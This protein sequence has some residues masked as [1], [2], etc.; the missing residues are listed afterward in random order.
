MMDKLRTASG[1]V[2]LK[3]L[4]GAI[5][6]S[7]VL[8]GVGNYLVGSGN[9][10]AVKV[11]DETISRTQLENAVSNARNEQKQRL[12]ELYTV[13]AAEPSYVKQLRE[14][15]LNNL[16]D[17][18]LVQNYLK[19]LGLH[20][21]DEQVKTFIFSVD[22]FKKDGHFNNEV[23]A[24]M[25]ANAGYTPDTYAEA[26]RHSLQ[27]EQLTNGIVGSDFMLKNELQQMV[28]LV[29]Q[30]RKIRTAVIDTEQLA[31]KQK[32]SDDEIQS[33]YQL[34]K[35]QYQQPD[36]YQVS[37]IKLDAEKLQK[38]PDPQQV[39]AWYDN[40]KDDYTRPQRSRYSVIQV[41]TEQQANE[42]LKKLQQGAD[43][44]TLAKQSSIDVVSSKKGGD[45]G[46]LE[47]ATTPNEFKS[48]HLTTKGQLSSVIKSQFGFI[49]VRLDDVQAAE[50][51][52]LEQVRN[53]VLQ[54]VQH[55]TAINQFYKLQQVVNDA[56]SNDASSLNS[57]EQASGIK[58]QT[59]EWFS[60]N[61]VPAAL[62]FEPVKQV[63]FD[64]SLLPNKSSPGVNSGTI[65]VDGDRAFV[66]RISGFKPAEL[67]PLQAVHDQV[68]KALSQQKAL[69]QAK[70]LAK[71]IV[72]QLQKGNMKALDGAGLT[73]SASQNVERSQRG[74]VAAAAFAMTEPKD[75][76]VSYSN[77][78]DGKNN[79]VII[80]LD[81]VI[82]GTMTADKQKAMA[83]GVSSN[84]AQ[85]VFA[86]LLQQLR[87]QSTIKY[88]AAASD[89]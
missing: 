9:D 3:I 22:A 35:A 75:H 40:H 88:G 63:L 86:A 36:Q 20:V 2:V 71:N 34:H 41:K 72:T 55:E 45:M 51:Q 6:V 52:P 74:E 37:Y 68:V 12:G 61:S 18:L 13:L 38:T 77:A 19:K 76:H 44:S 1:H 85:L 27:T 31:K 42:I 48:A 33:Y 5:I 16:I 29:A 56:A 53:A 62:N 54:K 59:T 80:A 8:T 57:A 66:V 83:E 65:S 14:Q 47:E 15:T 79:L 39:Q 17:Q 70:Q 30:Q 11:D 89:S 32:L 43:F 7:F 46:W 69:D 73:F 26:L 49:I 87:Q 25:L 67:Q 60:K 64:G 23:F 84:N 58:V 78:I 24:S 28:A 82:P 10:Y 4:L 81:Q 21:S 50:T